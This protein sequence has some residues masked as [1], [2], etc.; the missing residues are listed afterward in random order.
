[1]KED[2]AGVPPEVSSSSKPVRFQVSAE[3]GCRVF[4]AGTFNS[5]DPTKHRMKGTKGVYSITIS[6]PTGRHE[7]K[8]VVDG[9]WSIDPGNPD[10]V[11]N[12]HGT[13]NSVIK[14]E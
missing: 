8:F 1:M 4:V 3:P 6:V 5:W 12:K 9:V 2:N 14:I 10:F 13:L 7:Y 11:P